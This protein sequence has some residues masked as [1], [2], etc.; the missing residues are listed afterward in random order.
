MEGMDQKAHEVLKRQASLR[1]ARGP[2]DSWWQDIT[3]HVMPRKADITDDRFD[4]PVYEGVYK[5][6]SAW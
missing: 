4:A 3:E 2:W 6:L 1:A 5:M